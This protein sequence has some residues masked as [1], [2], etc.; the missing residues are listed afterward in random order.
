MTT[1]TL[2]KV[3]FQELININNNLYLPLKKFNSLSDFKSICSRMRLSNGRFFPIPILL[4]IS[5]LEKERIIKYS[6]IKLL[7]RKKK[8]DIWKISKFFNK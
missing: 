4:G 8:L 3:T 5:K 1:L 2:N 6:K 7:Y